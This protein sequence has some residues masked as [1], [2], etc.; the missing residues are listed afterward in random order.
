MVDIKNL[1]NRIVSIRMNSGRMLHLQPHMVMKEISE[2]QTTNNPR[3]E[4]LEKRGV[5][6]VILK[7]ANDDKGSTKRQPKS[8]TSG[9]GRQPKSSKVENKDTTKKEK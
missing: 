5:I 9:G 2:A 3:I 7:G 1:T 8:S 4:K 6:N